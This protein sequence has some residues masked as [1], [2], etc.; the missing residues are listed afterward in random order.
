VTSAYADI[1]GQAH[2]VK[3]ATVGLIEELSA[4][5]FDKFGNS[6]A[7]FGTLYDLK[8][9]K[10]DAEDAAAELQK[11]KE[12]PEKHDV[13]QAQLAS[14]SANA[15]H[16]ETWFDF[17]GTG[18]SAP[19]GVIQDMNAATG[20]QLTLDANPNDAD[21]QFGHKQ[22]QN[23]LM[24][25]LFGY[26]GNDK[27][28]QIFGL[29]S[30]SMDIPGATAEVASTQQAFAMN[31]T[32]MT[33][34]DME[35]AQLAYDGLMADRNSQIITKPIVAALLAFTVESNDQKINQLA[36]ER[37]NLAV[38]GGGHELLYNYNM[39]TAPIMGGYRMIGGN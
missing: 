13:R 12:Q 24:A 17:R 9:A 7:N 39:R 29:T 37:A 22:A 16:L 19:L 1:D 26:K 6:F 38:S 14:D 31:P 34:I 3:V 20:A 33:E 27:L 5:T 28:S 23:D 8:G 4:G 21:A 11:A 35:I 10:A 32:R 36:L 15:A 30:T 25:T 2:N 18:N